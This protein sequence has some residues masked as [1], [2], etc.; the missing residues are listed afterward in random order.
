M[1]DVTKV[2]LASVIYDTAKIF[3][4]T[5]SYPLLLYKKYHYTRVIVDKLTKFVMFTPTRTDMDTEE[6]A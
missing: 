6:T 3:R 2:I 1:T 4:P 5:S